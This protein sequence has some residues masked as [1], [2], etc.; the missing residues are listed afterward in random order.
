MF[1]HASIKDNLTQ[2]DPISKCHD[3]PEKQVAYVTD[4][5]AY[6]LMY[7]RDMDINLVTCGI[8]A[9]NIIYYEEQFENQL[10]TLY[11]NRSG[12]VYYCKANSNIQKRSNTYGV[13]YS[14]IPIPLIKKRF[15][16]NVYKLIKKAI[17]QKKIIV[18][19]Y[20]DLTKE[21][22]QGLDEHYAKKIIEN[23]FFLD[24]MKLHNFYKNNYIDAWKIAEKQK[25]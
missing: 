13:Y 19:K 20:Q 8:K 4:N 24:N 5:F 14:T 1:Y 10:E 25:K 11:K 12:Y 23:N 2:L 16:P 7:I 15:I 3:E 6:A 17:K 21:R 18:Q 22:K 9:D